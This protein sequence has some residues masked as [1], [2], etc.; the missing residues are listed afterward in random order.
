M[1]QLLLVGVALM[2]LAGGSAQAADLWGPPPVYGV[3]ARPPGLFSWSGFYLGG[4]AGWG[5]GTFEIKTPGDT[6]GFDVKGLVAGGQGGFNW[7]WNPIVFGVEVDVSAKQFNGND[8]GTGGAL[9]RFDGR[10]GWGGTARGRLGYAVDRWLFF[11]TGGWALLN[12]NYASTILP[13]GPGVTF[14]DRDNGWV[15]GGGIEQAFAPNW[16]AK[17]EYLHANY[18]DRNRAA[19]IFAHPWITTLATDEVRFG[20]NYKF[21]VAY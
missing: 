13:A 8:G 6:N 3:A 5:W 14:R 1:R 2:G 7:Q 20:L 4:H 11:A 21:D 10:R 17:I 16:S 15:V 12:H 9:D 19:A 18:G